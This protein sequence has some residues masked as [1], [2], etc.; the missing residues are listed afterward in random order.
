MISTLLHTYLVLQCCLWLILLCICYVKQCLGFQ[1]RTHC[2]DWGCLC[3]QTV[4]WVSSQSPP[5]S[6]ANAKGNHLKGITTIFYVIVTSNSNVRHC[7]S[8]L[9][10][11]NTSL[12]KSTWAAFHFKSRLDSCHSGDDGSIWHDGSIHVDFLG[13][14]E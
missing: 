10:L 6:T 14:G 12:C 3:H 13:G 1:S 9:A 5:L 8:T 11:C 2:W 4:W 7:S